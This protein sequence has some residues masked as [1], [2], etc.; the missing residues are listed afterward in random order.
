[1]DLVALRHYLRYQFDP[2]R[3]VAVLAPA[4]LADRLDGLHAEPGF[5]AQSLDVHPLAEGSR[6]LGAFE[7]EAR[8][9]THTNESY[10]FRVAARSG[11]GSSTPATAD[12]PATF[13]R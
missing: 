4:G 11:M 8:L 3:R 2:P 7:I 13:G 6:A 9:V 12:G 10:A 5:T 1:M